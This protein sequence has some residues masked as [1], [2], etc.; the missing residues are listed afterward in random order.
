MN[1]PTKD[2]FDDTTMTFG[3]HLEILRVHLIRA[4]IGLVI[5][6]IFC[7]FKGAS[8][9]EFVRRPVDRALQR[10]SQLEVMD[11]TGQLKGMQQRFRESWGLD[12]LTEMF[13]GEPE[14][15]EDPDD[16]PA[17]ETNVS[18]KPLRRPDTVTVKLEIDELARALH[19]LDPDRF[20]RPPPAPA[21]AN[22]DERPAPE[23]GD[24]EDPDTTSA[25]APEGDDAAPAG[26]GSNE[27]PAAA[28]PAPET[29]TLRLRA[30][31]FAQFQ[32]T[33]EQ[34]R[35]PVTLTVQEAFLTYLK[36]SL[37]AGVLLSSPW[38]FYQLW[39]FIAAGLYPHEKKFVYLYGVLSLVLFLVGAVFC[40]YGVFP[41][42]LR[43][44]LGFNA[45][46]EI[47]P[48][49]RLSEWISFAVL[50]PVMFGISFQL[51]LVML[52]L[53]RISIFEVSHY[54]E[55]RRM[56]VLVIAVIS[57]L[58]T[59]ADPMSMLMM[60]LPLVFLYELGIMLCK[61]LPSPS[62]FEEPAV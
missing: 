9:V 50:L 61:H 31:E 22:R 34:A 4:I 30:P 5:A 44:L 46:L 18:K 33:A 25:P 19:R 3:E 47:H 26:N 7:L 59:P 56:A 27:S 29:I 2:L 55:Q 37:I 13:W 16:D 24:E 23:E 54:R 62:P 60:M 20:P 40:F 51:P 1:Q 36:V 11:D 21:V 6:T 8:I 49:I 43:F 14:T 52:F 39:L 53:E 57:M 32:A 17:D 48:Q 42:V 10:H 38:I 15:P 35:R 41:F 45:T 12:V 28:P 58:L